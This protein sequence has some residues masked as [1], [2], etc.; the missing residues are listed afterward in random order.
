MIDNLIIIKRC[1]T[2]INADITV[3]I[4]VK[5]FLTFLLEYLTIINVQKKQLRFAHVIAFPDCWFYIAVRF[6][7]ALLIA[8]FFYFLI[9]FTRNRIRP[10]PTAL[11]STIP[12][13]V[14]TTLKYIQ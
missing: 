7:C 12:I 10:L 3:F 5:Q 13:T 8:R 6:G 9:S 1:E 11:V 2:S 4:N 14:I